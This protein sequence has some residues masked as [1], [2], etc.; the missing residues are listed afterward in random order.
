MSACDC[1]IC[2]E[3]IGEKNNCVTECGH[4]YHMSCLMKWT[5][6]N[7]SCPACR[8]KINKEEEVKEVNE[9]VA[10]MISANPNAIAYLSMLSLQVRGNREHVNW[11][12]MGEGE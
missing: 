12:W 6:K 8:N 1:S 11:I 7:N 5:M 3:T 9:D 10:F 4:K 2:L